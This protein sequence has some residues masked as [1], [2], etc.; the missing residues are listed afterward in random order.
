MHKLCDCTGKWCDGGKDSIWIWQ[1][2]FPCCRL[3]CTRSFSVVWMEAG[4]IFLYSSKNHPHEICSSLPRL[5]FWKN[6]LWNL[7]NKFACDYFERPENDIKTKARESSQTSLW[8]LL[9]K[10][11][12]S[13]FVPLCFLVLWFKG[14]DTR[15][16]TGF[17]SNSFTYNTPRLSFL[18]TFSCEDLLNVFFFFSFFVM[19]LH[20][21]SRL[22]QILITASH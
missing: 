16:V 14:R 10:Q 3:Q 11:H 12:L 21:Q 1:H 13:F 20:L 6:T 19:L 15:A 4:F 22:Q 9:Y 7:S 2:Q 17:D 5:T 18:F 8:W